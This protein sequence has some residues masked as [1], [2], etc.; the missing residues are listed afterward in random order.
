MKKHLL[1]LFSVLCILNLTT[2][3][4]VY[5]FIDGFETYSPLLSNAGLIGAGYQTDS[6]K[7]YNNTH[8]YSSTQC[9]TIR[10]SA[11]YSNDVLSTPVVG[12]ITGST[13]LEFYTRSCSAFGPY[14]RQHFLRTGEN[15]QVVAFDSA[16]STTTPLLLIDS[17]NQ[18][19]GGAYVKYTV[20]LGALAGSNIRVKF[21][22]SAFSTYFIDIDSIVIKDS[23]VVLPPA[24]DL[25][26]TITSPLCPGGSD[27]SIL[28][29]PSGGTAPYTYLWSD[30]TT[31]DSLVGLAAGNY[32]V[33]VTDST[34]ATVTQSVTVSNPI[35]MSSTIVRTNPSCAGDTN[36]TATVHITGGAQPYSYF[37]NTGGNDSTIINLAAGNYSVTVT[38]NNGCT[39]TRNITVQNPR[40]MNIRFTTLDESAIGASDGYSH[41]RVISGGTPGFTY[42]WSNGY[43]GTNND[44]LTAGSYCVT[45][46]DTNGCTVTGC[47][48]INVALDIAIEEVFHFDVDCYGDSTGSVRVRG[49]NGQ[50]PYTYDWGGGVT[51]AMQMGLAAG[52]YNI[53]ITDNAGR[54]GTADVIITQPTQVTA[55]I[56][57]T[58]T[59]S[60]STTGTATAVVSG[61]IAPY[62]YL[63]TPGGQMTSSISGLGQGTYTVEVTDNNGCVNTFSTTIVIEGIQ[64]IE[65][66][67]SV[68]LYP[69]PCVNDLFIEFKNS[70]FMN[71]SIND[72][73]GRSILKNNFIQNKNIQSIDVSTLAKGQYIIEMQT[74]DGAFIS[75][76]FIKL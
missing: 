15:I 62:S 2:K 9:A 40:A 75:K 41:V 24:F 44:N 35:G 39:V 43:N 12:A 34:G 8:A 53:T 14:P 46:T 21:N 29:A 65:L 38:D 7:L 52:T 76:K 32:N 30:S 28:L 27:G 10:L 13:Q 42:S 50:F 60:G 20:N 63:W 33:T 26:P 1:F 74:K 73:T 17:T 51:G 49:I 66:A 36:G 3:A 45:V 16:T 37:W 69:S 54:T 56:N 58:A 71:Y 11:A 5:P 18:N 4:Q 68:S 57:T 64:N 25:N 59:S 22:V 47:D 48:T 55:T 31:F 23:V 72:L 61:G 19:T 67:N 6:F 70:Q